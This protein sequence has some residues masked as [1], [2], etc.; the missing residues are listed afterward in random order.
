MPSTPKYLSILNSLN[1]CK[2]CFLVTLKIESHEISWGL[3][4]IEGN[5]SMVSLVNVS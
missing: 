5:S 2:T 4:L 3:L 1:T